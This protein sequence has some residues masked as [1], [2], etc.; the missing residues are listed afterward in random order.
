MISSRHIAAL[1]LLTVLAGHPA[2]ALA[3]ADDPRARAKALTADGRQLYDK[4]DYEGALQ[5]FQAAFDTF[6][7]AKIQFNVGQAYKGLA[8]D[9]EAIQAFEEF[10]A[11]E[12]DADPAARAEAG[13]FV[14]ELRKKVAAVDL[15]CDV[16]GASVLV[17]G[18]LVGTTPIAKPILVAAGPHQIVVQKETSAAPFVTAI[19]PERG[20]TV[21]LWANL[22]SPAG[23]PPPSPRLADAALVQPSVVQGTAPRPIYTRWWF[24]TAV[25]VAVIGGSVAAVAATRGSGDPSASLGTQKAF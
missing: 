25:G 3:Q 16:D 21:H 20:A 9:V 4:G 13:R 24:W 17:D 23:A 2:F 6:P 5:K 1:A 14:A 8:R 19:A 10:L 15:T 12:P 7:S 22:A 18:R 11:R